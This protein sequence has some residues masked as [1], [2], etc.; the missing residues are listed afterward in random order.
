MIVHY[1]IF[2]RNAVERSGETCNDKA[3]SLFLYPL[4]RDTSISLSV[5][6]EA[7]NREVW[8]LLKSLMNGTH[9]LPVRSPGGKSVVG[10][11]VAPKLVLIYLSGP[12]PLICPSLSEALWIPELFNL[13]KGNPSEYSQHTISTISGTEAFKIGIKTWDRHHIFVVCGHSPILNI[14]A[15]IPKVEDDIVRYELLFY[16]IR[17]DHGTVERQRVWSLRHETVFRCASS[18]MAYSMW[19]AIIYAGDLR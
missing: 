13:R 16:H 7:M 15:I 14:K 17:T 11:Y 4:V 18:I 2:R 9:T 3:H 10:G 19:I 8:H 1:T 6:S 12:T 5:N